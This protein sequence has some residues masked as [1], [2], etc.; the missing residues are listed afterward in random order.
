MQCVHTTYLWCAQGAF[1]V[2]QVTQWVDHALEKL[3]LLVCRDTHAKKQTY[4]A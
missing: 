2:A 1:I 4:T 3:A